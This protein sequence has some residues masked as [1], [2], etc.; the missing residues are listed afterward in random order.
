MELNCHKTNR[1]KSLELVQIELWAVP[2]LQLQLALN[3]QLSTLNSQ[4]STL[5]SQLSTILHHEF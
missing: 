3:S 5:N 4:L 1:L 2:T